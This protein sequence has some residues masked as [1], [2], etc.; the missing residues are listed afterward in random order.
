MDRFKAQL[1]AAIVVVGVVAIL[2]ALVVVVGRF[3]DA[4]DAAAVL[5]PITTAIAGLVGAFFGVNL[6]QQGKDAA[7]QA[8]A[9]AE[10]DKN[11]AQERAERYAAMLPQDVAQQVQEQV[12]F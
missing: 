12:Q 2:A 6:G 3:T 5:A 1:G 8:R 10:D 7:D 4:K 11:K 9:K